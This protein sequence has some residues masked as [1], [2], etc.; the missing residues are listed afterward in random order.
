MTLY[1][2]ECGRPGVTATVP[3]ETV[4]EVIA[5]ASALFNVPTT[6]LTSR[7]RRRR[8]VAARYACMTVLRNE[9]HLSLLEIGDWFDR[10]H[11]TVLYGLRNAPADMVQRLTD[12][13]AAQT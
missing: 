11:T 9:H 12:N 3:A 13:L 4:G 10:D 8:A 7:N 2:P 1:C 6:E 5:A